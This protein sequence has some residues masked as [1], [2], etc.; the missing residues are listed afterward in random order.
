MY[1]A[2]FYDYSLL[3]ADGRKLLPESVNVYRNNDN[4]FQLTT[5][6]ADGVYFVQLPLLQK[7]HIVLI[8]NYTVFSDVIYDLEPG[9]RQERIKVLGYRTDDWNGT[10]NIPGF[11]FDNAICTEWQSYQDYD[12]GDTVYY[13]EFYYIAKIHIPGTES[14][15]AESWV[16]LDEKPTSE[17]MPNLDYKAKQFKDYYDLDTDNFDTNQ[18]RIAQHLIGYQKRKYLSNIINDDVSQY[19]IL[20]R[21]YPR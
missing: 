15:E 11:V 14:F 4:E 9:Y 5:N 1:L 10:L 13:K 2:N 20:S 8:D 3:K 12:I 21:I 17:L 7:E 19:K 16:R 18:Q 6:G